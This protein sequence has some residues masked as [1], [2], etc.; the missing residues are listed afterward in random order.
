MLGAKTLAAES[1]RLSAWVREETTRWL[2]VL[3][4]E[5]GTEGKRSRCFE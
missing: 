2:T 4:S 5:A 1:R 3:W